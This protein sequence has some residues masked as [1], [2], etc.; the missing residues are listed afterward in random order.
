MQS[1]PKSAR[2]AR[3]P[4]RLRQKWWL[5]G[6]GRRKF[7]GIGENSLH[8]FPSTAPGYRGQRGVADAGLSAFDNLRLLTQTDACPTQSFCLSPCLRVA[9]AHRTTTHVVERVCELSR[10]VTRDTG[11]AAAESRL[12]SRGT[13]TCP[14]NQ[15]QLSM[16]NPNAHPPVRPVPN[17]PLAPIAVPANQDTEGV[18][19]HVRPNTPPS[20][21][22]CPVLVCCASQFH[23]TWWV[24]D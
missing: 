24:G 18:P 17:Q 3:S 22:A 12:F 5:F 20:E 7:V 6:R 9:Y 21:S 11:A 1:G 14:S 23:L 16:A 13:D 19:P 15:V 4:P 10:C 8:D 2:D